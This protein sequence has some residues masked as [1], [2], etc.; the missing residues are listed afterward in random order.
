MHMVDL[1]NESLQIPTSGGM[2]RPSLTGSEES[3]SQSQYY[4]I[5]NGF[6]ASAVTFGWPVGTGIGGTP[7]PQ[8]TFT[9]VVEFDPQGS[10][11]IIVG[12]P[13][14]YLD[15]IPH[16]IEIGLQPANG[17]SVAPVVSGATGQ[18]A[19]IQIDGMSGATRIYRP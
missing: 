16:Y 10:A 8:Y 12:P 4:D 7:A 18:I 6:C 11:R 5:P 13:A 17:T 15:A 3:T 9:K 14:N 2:A 19:A 1:Q